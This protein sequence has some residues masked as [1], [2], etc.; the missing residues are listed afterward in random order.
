[1]VERRQRSC[2]RTIGVLGKIKGN[3]WHKKQVIYIRFDNGKVV[4]YNKSNRE[5]KNGTNNL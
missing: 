4:W 5:V 3:I 2:I 1:M